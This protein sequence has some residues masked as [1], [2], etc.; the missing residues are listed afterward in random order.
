MNLLRI[1]GNPTFSP[2]L[3]GICFKK[4]A[5]SQ[6]P[7]LFQSTPL[8]F[9]IAPKN[10]Q[11]QKETHLPT[12]IF[13]GRAV[14]FRGCT[15]KK[16]SAFHEFSA[17]VGI[18][19]PKE[20]LQGIDIEP[21][22]LTALVV[23]VQGEGGE[24][25]RGFGWRRWRWLSEKTHQL[26]CVYLVICRKVHIIPQKWWVE[27]DPAS[28]WDGMQGLKEGNETMQGFDVRMNFWTPRKKKE[29]NKWPDKS[30]QSRCFLF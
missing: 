18:L 25:S 16:F 14:K 7:R 26:V 12:I 8:K 21:D 24:L 9:N 2:P 27:D 29:R 10:R 17:Q 19:A 6:R 22:P 4:K 5:V 20:K 30:I 15:S 13:Q 1:S 28:Y 11:S 3:M 23:R